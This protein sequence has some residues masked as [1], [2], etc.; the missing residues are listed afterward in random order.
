MGEEVLMP[1]DALWTF[2]AILLH[3]G[4]RKSNNREQ[5]NVDMN[6]EGFR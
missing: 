3:V 6:Y 1:R 2:Y 4:L 5:E